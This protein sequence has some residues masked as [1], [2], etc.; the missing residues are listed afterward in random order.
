MQDSKTEYGM[1]SVERR[2]PVA[3]VTIDRPERRNAIDLGGWKALSCLAADIDRDD[4]VRAVVFTGAGGRAFSAGA[5]IS[6]FELVR[7]DSAQAREYGDAIDGA[8]TAVERMSKPTVA[9]IRGFCVGGGCDLAA[10]CDVRVATED[11]T[12]GMPVARLGILVSYDEMRRL[13]RLVGY[14]HTKDLLLTGRLLGAAEAN[15]IGLVSRVVPPCDLERCVEELGAKIAALAPLSHRLHKEMM[16][17]LENPGGAAEL[18]PEDE[19]IQYA[20]FDSADYRE[21][22]A[23]F[24]ER[25]PPQFGGI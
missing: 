20:A 4:E 21:G 5:D 2:G 24:L 3:L 15:R 1:F 23:A 7:N 10:A 6:E 25:R 14:G 16:R 11:S 18:T 19:A 9:A 8:L 12:F 22:R 13:I 17:V